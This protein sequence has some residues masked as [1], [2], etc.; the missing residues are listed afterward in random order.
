MAQQTDT[1]DAESVDT[2]DDPA[3]GVVELDGGTLFSCPGPECS[4]VFLEY[5]PRSIHISRVHR[6]SDPPPGGGRPDEPVRSRSR[7]ADQTTPAGDRRTQRRD[8]S[9]GRSA[10]RRAHPGRAGHA[11]RSLLDE[12][13]VPKVVERAVDSPVRHIEP[14]AF[15]RVDPVF[16]GPSDREETAVGV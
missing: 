16:P 2:D 14:G 13:G 9:C 3:A 8:R 10:A 15:V 11:R 7:T 12:P 6:E 5:G 1:T 4:R